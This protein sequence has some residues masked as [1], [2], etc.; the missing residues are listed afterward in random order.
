MIN[1]SQKKIEVTLDFESKKDRGH[2]LI[3][4]KKDRAHFEIFYQVNLDIV[5]VFTIG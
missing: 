4:P 2:S 1:T 3:F 5:L